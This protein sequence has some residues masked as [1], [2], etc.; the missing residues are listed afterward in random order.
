MNPETVDFSPKMRAVLAAARRPTGTGPRAAVTGGAVIGGSYTDWSQLT[1]LVQAKSLGRDAGP[2]EFSVRGFRVIGP[3]TK[4][5]AISVA[6][7]MPAGS[8]TTLARLSF[9]EAPVE[10]GKQCFY[11][12]FL[13]FR[14]SAGDTDG[15]IENA[16][17]VVVDDQLTCHVVGSRQGA[18]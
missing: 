2:S 8:E 4:E 5:D 11:G 6:V 12:A 18:G 3:G 9:P 14:R 10:A 15:D 1:L 16:L 13:D 7:S 17:F